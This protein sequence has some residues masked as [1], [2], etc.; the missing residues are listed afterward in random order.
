MFSWSHSS[1]YPQIY[2]FIPN[3]AQQQN[4]EH[5]QRMELQKNLEAQ[6]I[7]LDSCVTMMNSLKDFLAESM[8]TI[9]KELNDVQSRLLVEC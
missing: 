2:Y 3:E 5:L 7:K 4:S 9:R 8:S 1:N 6:R